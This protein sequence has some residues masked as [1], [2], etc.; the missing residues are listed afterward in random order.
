MTIVL[1]FSCLPAF[2][3]DIQYRYEFENFYIHRIRLAFESGDTHLWINE[4]ITDLPPGLPVVGIST[5][6]LSIGPFVK[7]GLLKEIDNNS[8]YTVNSPLFTAVSSL[9]P[10][11]ASCVPGSFGILLA[12]LSGQGGMYWIAQPGTGYQA[13]SYVISNP[14][15]AVTLETALTCSARTDAN[16]ATV[17]HG[18]AK[19]VLRLKPLTISLSAL[20]SAVNC[21]EFGLLSHFTF[22]YNAKM[23]QPRLFLEY[24][25]DC[26]VNPAGKTS[27]NLLTA[28]WQLNATP[29]ASVAVS[30]TYRVQ[31][32]KPGAA[33]EPYLPSDE[34]ISLESDLSLIKRINYSFVLNT[35]IEQCVQ[36]TTLGAS[37][38][39][40]KLSCA[41]KLRSGKANWLMQF[42]AAPGRESVYKAIIGLT[43]VYKGW[44]FLADGKLGLAPQLSWEGSLG[45]AWEGSQ[46]KLSCRIDTKQAVSIG[47]LPQEK[48]S[49]AALFNFKLVWETLQKNAP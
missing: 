20:I 46:Y 12:P 43:H 10:D 7:T 37:S 47:N 14:V 36:F 29:W 40:L 9:K 41:A 1:G 3:L 27:Q 39:C 35:V 19:T 32:G 30:A 31:F 8:C 2:C 16:P 48:L 45:A 44:Q 4:R 38:R 15:K 22:A 5:P 21:E 23:W 25:T 11:T 34:S 18:A 49:P 26:Y 13:G 28:A 6:F 33:G 24:C 42:T 17:V